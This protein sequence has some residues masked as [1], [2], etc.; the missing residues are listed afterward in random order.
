[1]TGVDEG[2]I[3]LSLGERRLLLGA[4]PRTRGEL[5]AWVAHALGV[6]V[7]D[8][9]LVPGHASPL[10]YLEHAFF[11]GSGVRDCVVWASRGGG[12]TFYAAVATTLDL[13]FKPG[14]EVMILGGS[15]QQ[16]QRMLAH[17]RGFF[18]SPV[19]APMVAGPISDRRVVVRN[20]SMAEVLAQSHTSV[21][22]ARPQKLRCDEA[23]LFHPDVWAAAQLVTRSRVCGGVMVHGTVE[24]LSTWHR[25]V[26]LM[27][28]LIGESE[29]GDVASPARRVFRWNVVDV[30]ERCPDR[31]V[32]EGCALHQECGGRAKG[33][34][35]A[36]RVGGHVTVDDAIT[37]KRR[38]DGETWRAEMVCDR[39][40]RTGA[41]YPGFD[42]AVHVAAFPTPEAGAGVAMVGGIDFG[43]R[44][45]T[46]VVWGAVGA[47]ATVRICGELV[48]RETTMEA[49]ARMVR[50]APWPMP[51]WFGVDPAG[52]QRSSVS[53]MSPVVALRREGFAIRSRRMG[54]VDG[55]RLVRARMTP[56]TG[57]PTLMIHPRCEVLIRSL[58]SYRFP[59]SG[60][61]PETPVKDGPDHAADA[62]RYL[63]TNLPVSP[64]HG[65]RAFSY[66]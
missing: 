46:V 21:R 12:K 40:V 4:A 50:E 15:L 24:A 52:H 34:A 42:P 44:D 60:T 39:P 28:G 10:D 17:L 2:D 38:T 31:H 58:R 29:L 49:L 37:L 41:V 19:L 45:P 56:A 33:T 32:C 54:V 64:D 51:E 27:A 11:E 23:D 62:L 55:L 30:L 6:R 59:E 7:P 25:P 66:L 16:S 8:R 35:G 18:R 43:F 63:I 61:G 53:G 1:M 57:S 65:V 3:E 14:I 48:T 22:G 13:V 5:S 47:D 26:G 9:A 20:G 36:R